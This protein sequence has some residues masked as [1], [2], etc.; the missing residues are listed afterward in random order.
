VKYTYGVEAPVNGRVHKATVTVRD[1]ESGRIVLTDKSDLE[2]MPERSKTAKRLAKRTG[3]PAEEVEAKLE[4]GWAA[5]VHERDTMVKEKRD[6]ACAPDDVSVEVLDTHPSA[7]RR[8]L[9]LVDGR[10]YAAAWLY[11]QVTVRQS[12]DRETGDAT[13]Y[14]PPLVRTE[15]FLVVVRDDGQA[16]TEQP[17]LLPDA[18]P[19]SELR[20][21]VSLP[22]QPP[23]DRTWSG[24]GVKRFLAG[25]RPD[26]AELF[27]RVVGVV[28]RYID[29]ARSLAPQ[30]TLCE[31]VA[32]Y[33]LGTYL[34]DA[35]NVAGYQWP[36]GDKGAGKTTFL[37]VV[38]EMAYLGLLVLAGGSYASLRDLAD[39]GA[40]LAFDD[41]EGIMD[42]KKADPDK[43]ALLLAGNRRGAVVPVKEK[44]AGDVWV[45]RYVNAF[46]PRLFS[47]IRLPDDVLASRTV[48]VPLVRSG[49]ENRAKAN[50]LD[51]A[52]WPCDRRRLV[53]DLWALGL[54]HLPQL[55]AYDGQAAERS[56]LVGRDL[57]PWRVILAVALWLQD[58]YGVGGLFDRMEKLSRDYQAE[59]SDLE[60][61]NPVR[62]AIVALGRML[63]ARNNPEP[64][65]FK[66]K[67]LA[68]EME[69]V[70]QEEGLVDEEAR[71]NGA[72]FTK[73]DKVGW[74]LR[75]LRF[76][77][78]PK[79]QKGRRWST[80]G[81]SVQALARAY[82]MN[83][84]AAQ[85]GDGGEQPKGEAAAENRETF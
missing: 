19:L 58:E 36:N 51:Y 52:A 15:S 30:Q 2:A 85:R 45:T 35:F 59:R 83:L 56:E 14:D 82:G 62:V 5:A 18:K 8:P 76:Q 66:T 84:G 37:Q 53:D 43:R 25:E 26:P 60:P 74:L 64:M 79:E 34:L 54:A 46:C 71:E 4:E 63:A 27:G 29:F 75:R 13:T 48:T 44:A 33:T 9:A 32:C 11:A 22:T 72:K 67:E 10:A 49:D 70:A 28:D 80:T 17:S 21:A 61:R 41:A 24:A 16:F 50:P 12:V 7:V 65:V 73:P 78:E 42:P 69:L 20:L 77:R 68:D 47:A 3:D 39:Y 31:M 57:E 81:A 23:P 6:A 55:H 1:A 40:T 38:V